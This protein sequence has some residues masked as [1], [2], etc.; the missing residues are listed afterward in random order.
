MLYHYWLLRYV[1]DAAKPDT[2]GVGI[3]VLGQEPSDIAIRIVSRYEEIPDIGGPRKEFALVLRNLQKEIISYTLQQEGFAISHTSSAKTYLE[4]MRRQN[5][6]ILRVEAPVP[7]AGESAQA[8]C[9]FLFERLVT[10]K[11]SEQRPANRVTQI[12]KKTQEQYQR[13]PVVAERL[14]ERPQVQVHKGS[15][16]IDLAVIGDSYQELVRAFSFNVTPT[17]ELRDRGIAFAHNVGKLRKDG[18]TVRSS[19]NI[20]NIHPTEAAVLAVV[21]Y[22]K[23][24]QQI[25]VFEEATADW[26]ELGIEM[27]DPS[28]VPSHLYEVES[29]L[30]S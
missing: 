11:Q 24:R 13:V 29:K 8:L 21:E 17:A 3:V 22:P 19:G 7:A 16:K 4:R 18:A 23:D 27:L 1:P 28:R 12:R 9:D 26:G 10:R 2:V 30:A 6:G 15:P 25:E 14:F 5:Y 20:Y